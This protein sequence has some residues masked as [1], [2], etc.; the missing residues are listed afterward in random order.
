MSGG[1]GFIKDFSE[2]LTKYCGV[3]TS[4]HAYIHKGIGYTYDYTASSVAAGS[5]VKIGFSTP[6]LTPGKYLHW[7]PSSVS[8]TANI[9][10][11]TLYENTSFTGGTESWPNNNNRE[12]DSAGNVLFYEDVTAALTGAKVVDTKAGGNFGNQP[13]GDGVTV[14]SSDAGDTTQTVTIYGTITGATTTVTSETLTLDGTNDVDSTTLTWQN[15]LGV[16]I[17]AATTGNIEV[18]ETS[19]GAAI[20]TITAGTTAAGIQTPTS[21]AGKDLIPWHDASGASTAPVGLIGTAPDGTA[22]TSVD[23]LNGTTAEAHGTKAF[24]TITKALIGAVASSVNVDIIVNDKPLRTF[25]IGSGGGPSSRG[26]GAGGG[27]EHELV[28]KENTSYVVHLENIG[29]TTASDIDIEIFYY[30]EDG[31]IA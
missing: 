3:I 2:G 11:Y 25:T 12:D 21:T 24:R 30:E 7:R 22:L 20:V 14:V 9:A 23:A 8:S 26:G 18:S 4:D 17:S 6:N 19:G 28:L 16:E 29:S 31:Y 13:A 1:S 15:I 5:G 10:R 27:A